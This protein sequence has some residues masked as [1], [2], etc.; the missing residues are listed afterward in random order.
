MSMR[1]AY[2]ILLIL[3]IIMGLW[4]YIDRQEN[5]CLSAG[6]CLKGYKFNTCDW[7]RRIVNEKSCEGQ[8]RWDKERE[9]CF[10]MILL[11]NKIFWN[12]PT[13]YHNHIMW[14]FCKNI[15]FTSFFPW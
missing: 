14:N 9:I 2:I 3:G 5:D 1:W 11:S 8:G 4:F 6:I 7:E 13:F 10:F 15:A 12:N